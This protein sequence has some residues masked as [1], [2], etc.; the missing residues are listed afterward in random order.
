MKI[1]RQSVCYW[2]EEKGRWVA[3]AG[4]YQIYVGM[5]SVDIHAE[6]VMEVVETFELDA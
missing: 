2:H 6:K 4:E 1:D 5:F 3:E